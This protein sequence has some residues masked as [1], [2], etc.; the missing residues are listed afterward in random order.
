M[1]VVGRV[2]WGWWCLLIENEYFDKVSSSE[3]IIN[4]AKHL[5]YENQ[6]IKVVRWWCGWRLGG[7]RVH[8]VGGS[9]WVVGEFMGWVGVWWCGKWWGAWWGGWL[10][11]SWCGSIYSPTHEQ[12]QCQNISFYKHPHTHQAYQKCHSITVHILTYT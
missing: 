5:K 12:L 3:K 1:V 4:L 6:N 9:G 2:W 11:C 8:G 7:W 10:E